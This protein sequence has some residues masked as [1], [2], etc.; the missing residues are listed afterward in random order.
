[1]K[2]FRHFRYLDRSLTFHSLSLS[3]PLSNE[4]KPP[5]FCFKIIPEKIA[6]EKAKHI[7]QQWYSNNTTIVFSTAK[8]VFGICVRVSEREKERVGSAKNNPM[9]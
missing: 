4:R 7:A 8:L 6:D 5:A 1:M 2:I 9:L 3:P